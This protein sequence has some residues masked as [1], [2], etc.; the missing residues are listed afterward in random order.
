MKVQFLPRGIMKIIKYNQSKRTK[1]KEIVN[2]LQGNKTVVVP[3]DTVY[4]L[5]GNATSKNVFK[6]IY[7][8]K[9]RPQEKSLP[10]LIK[11]LKMAKKIADISKRQ[12]KFLKTIWP[13]KV[14]VILKKLNDIIPSYDKMTIAL[15]ISS[16]ALINEIFNYINFPLI[17]TSANISGMSSSCDSKIIKKQFENS[18]AGK[19]NQP[20][21]FVDAKIL[22]ESQPSTIIDIT[23]GVLKI[24]RHGE[25]PEERLITIWQTTV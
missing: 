17:G 3:T 25:I 13:G 19:E 21:L 2:Y 24:I 10:I 8:I 16:F 23:E 12:E 1:I 20:D 22:P 15:R 11:D 9:Q 6:K 7:K 5:T 18:P 4:G 14:T